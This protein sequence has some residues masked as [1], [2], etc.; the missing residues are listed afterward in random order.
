MLTKTKLIHF[1][2][3]SCL[4]S[5]L[6]ATL[7]NDLEIAEKYQLDI[8]QYLRPAQEKVEI[9][10][11]YHPTSED[12]RRLQNYLKDSPRP[13]LQYTNHPET[14]WREERIRKFNFILE[15]EA[16]QFEIV[17]FNNSPKNKKNC[18]V[19][20]IS[21]NETYL[22]NLTALIDSLKSIGFDGHLIYR[23]GGWPNTKEGSLELFDIPYAF[24]ILAF[25]EVKNL[26]YKNCLWLDSCFLPLKKLDPIFEHIEKYGVFFHYNP[27]YSSAGHITDFATESFG[28]SLESFLRL[29]AV[30]SYAVGINLKSKRGSKLLCA[31][32]EMVQE[33]KLGFLSFIPEMAPLYI[34]VDRFNLQP[35]AANPNYFSSPAYITPETILLW[36]HE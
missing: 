13:E 26:G 1:F 33:Q 31:W 24:K 15:N 21:F 20:Y 11:W 27:Y 14:A 12:Y 28:I 9:S 35:Y 30:Q 8:G 6:F 3:F 2:L 5:P 34:L 4:S 10:D 36:N 22:R 23:V 29:G 18:I 7:E 32:Y 17:Y 25:L 16:P 19:T